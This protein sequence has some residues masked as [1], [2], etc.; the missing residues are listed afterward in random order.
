MRRPTN[1]R[2]TS[3]PP[4]TS[5]LTALSTSVGWAAVTKNRAA[6][7]L[8]TPP[9]RNPQRK[10]YRAAYRNGIVV[11]FPPRPVYGAPEDPRPPLFSPPGRRLLPAGAL[12]PTKAGTDT[13]FLD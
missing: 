5:R 6:S 7:K 10:T 12:T 4:L 2:P 11:L 3:T 13:G 1:A 9:T 8:K